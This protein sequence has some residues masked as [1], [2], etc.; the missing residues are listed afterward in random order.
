MMRP[1]RMIRTDMRQT[2]RTDMRQRH[3]TDTDQGRTFTM[4]RRPWPLL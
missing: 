4:R 3:R 2:I 1:L